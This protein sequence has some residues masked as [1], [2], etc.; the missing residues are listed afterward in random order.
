MIRG[1]AVVLVV[2]LL[3][4]AAFAVF[5]PHLNEVIEMDVCLDGGGV[6][7]NGA[8]DYGPGEGG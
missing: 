4:T 8:C 3:T 1:A 5:G 6:W 7:R 2:A